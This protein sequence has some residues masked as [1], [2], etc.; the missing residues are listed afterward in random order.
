LHLSQETAKVKVTR[1]YPGVITEIVDETEENV[2]TKPSTVRATL[3]DRL[4]EEATSALEQKQQIQTMAT[5]QKSIKELL[6]DMSASACPQTD[7]PMG[8]EASP[9]V[10]VEPIAEGTKAQYARKKRVRHKMRS[11]PVFGGSLF[12][13]DSGNAQAVS[14][15]PVAPRVVSSKK[16]D[17]W[18]SLLARPT[19]HSAELTINGES[20]QIRI[21]DDTLKNLRKGFSGET[22]DSRGFTVPGHIQIEQA[23]APIVNMLQGYVR[24]TKLASIKEGS[25]QDTNSEAN[26]EDVENL[27]EL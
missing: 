6:R 10:T 16:K 11:T 21:S 13:E 23:N 19:G 5:T 25:V 27:K 18:R 22:L 9:S 1:W 17:E 20:Y 4:L 15:G 12:G 8:G 14:S 7:V 3:E 2:K 26:S 24:N